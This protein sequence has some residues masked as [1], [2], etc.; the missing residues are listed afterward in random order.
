MGCIKSWV[1]KNA[2]DPLW[3]SFGY[4]YA[5]YIN[6]VSYYK[7][8]AVVRDKKIPFGYIGSNNIDK[9]VRQVYEDLK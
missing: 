4:F 1:V 3:Y 7:F 6:H 8:I 2:R 9:V 5:D